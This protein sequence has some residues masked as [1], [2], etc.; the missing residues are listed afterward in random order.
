MVHPFGNDPVKFLRKNLLTLHSSLDD[1]PAQLIRDDKTILVKLEDYTR[2][3]K[4]AIRHRR[5]K[6]L[7]ALV[8]KSNQKWW[9]KPTAVLAV[10]PAQDG[11]AGAFPAYICPFRYNTL[12]V[13][14]LGTDA[15]VMFTGDMDGCTFGVGMPNANGGVRVGHANAIQEVT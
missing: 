10:L 7:A 2:C 12:C 13:R 9:T 1:P 11:D 3:W 4:T 15:V 6:G 8:S 5:R 14:T